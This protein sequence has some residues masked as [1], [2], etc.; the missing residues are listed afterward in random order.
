MMKR[1]VITLGFTVLLMGLTGVPGCKKAAEVVDDDGTVYYLVAE[2]VP[3]HNDS[4]ILPLTDP[5]HIARA[6]EIVAGTHYSQIVSAYIARGDGDGRYRNKDLQGSGR[7]WSWHVSQFNGFADVT[8]EIYDS[9][10]TYVEDNLDFWLNNNQG[11]IGF[12]A[13]TVKRRVDPSEIQ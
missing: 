2:I 5:A 7:V 10:P 4:Y 9:W 1:I 8:A 13:Y 11:I 6:D 12:W 3:N